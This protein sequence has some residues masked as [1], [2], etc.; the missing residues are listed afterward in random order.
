MDMEAEICRF[1]KERTDS[2]LRIEEKAR[3]AITEANS[4]SLQHGAYQENLKLLIELSKREY[5]EILL[6]YPDILVL[7]FGR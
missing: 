7:L 6:L 3:K 2:V 5:S 4:V 1:L